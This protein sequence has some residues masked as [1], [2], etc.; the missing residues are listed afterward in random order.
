MPKSRPKEGALARAHITLSTDEIVKAVYLYLRDY[1]VD[2]A[3][4]VDIVLT[5]NADGEVIAT[6]PLDRAPL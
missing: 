1:G 4:E 3:R 2:T 6:V 5:E